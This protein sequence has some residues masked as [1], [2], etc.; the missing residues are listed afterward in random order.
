MILSVGYGFEVIYVVRSLIRIQGI[1]TGLL[2][3][4]VRYGFK[5][6]DVI[7]N[8]IPMT[9]SALVMG[10]VGFGLNLVMNSILWDIASIFICIIVYFG[11]LFLLF[12][13]TRREI[14]GSEY[15]QKILRKFKRNK[16]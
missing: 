15:A 16:N 1:V 9:V 12:P 7:R 10:A 2:I 5:I 6:Q 11:V 4:H 3:L 14:L 13:K 8:I